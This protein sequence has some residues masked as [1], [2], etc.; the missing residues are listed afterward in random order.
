M[1]MRFALIAL[2]LLLLSPARAQDLQDEPRELDFVGFQQFKEVS[3]VFVRTNEQARYHVNAG[4]DGVVVL[5]IENTGCSVANHLRHLDTHFF[6]GPVTLIQPKLIE[7]PSN[8]I[9]IDI[10]LRRGVT[11]RQSQKDNVINLDFPRE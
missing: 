2:G 9:E 7:G 5:T 1:R 11:A 3:R 4:R 10:F 6:N 8:S